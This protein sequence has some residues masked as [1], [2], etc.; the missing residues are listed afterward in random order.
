MWVQWKCNGS[1]VLKMEVGSMLK[2]EVGSMEVWYSGSWF[3]GSGAM[4]VGLVDWVQW[5]CGVVEVG[6]VEV[7]RSGGG[8]S[9]SVV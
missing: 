2:V 4:K 7:W 6:S 1:G 3:S 5:K 9:G 8:L